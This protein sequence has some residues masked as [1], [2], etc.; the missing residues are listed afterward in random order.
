MRSPGLNPP[1]PSPPHPSHMINFFIPL[2]SPSFVGVQAI[3]S[4]L[5]WNWART[6]PNPRMA[7]APQLLW[8]GHCSANCWLPLSGSHWLAHPGHFWPVGLAL[9]AQPCQTEKPPLHLPL[10]H[11][12][13]SLPPPHLFL[14][15]S[16][17]DLSS[18]FNCTRPPSTRWEFQKYV[19]VWLSRPKKVWKL[20]WMTNNCERG[21]DHIV[22][23]W[24][25]FQNPLNLLKTNRVLKGRAEQWRLGKT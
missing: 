24:T 12:G 21:T 22:R 16:N 14:S 19:F 13:L 15:L 10:H 17:W 6:I 4:I 1:L 23:G 9:G 20:F 8:L 11:R 25:E 7:S 5:H 18:F 3:C 2:P